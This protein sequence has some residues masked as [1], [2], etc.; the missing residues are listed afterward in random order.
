MHNI[1]LRVSVIPL[2][3][4]TNSTNSTITTASI[5]NQWSYVRVY[6]KNKLSSNNN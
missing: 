3:I 6:R 2:I 4:N 5:Y 1:I